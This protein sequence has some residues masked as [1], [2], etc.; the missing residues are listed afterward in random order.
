MQGAKKLACLTKFETDK[1][2]ESM[3]YDI[4]IN[5]KECALGKRNQT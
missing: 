1:D 4:A 2:D 5:A 3:V